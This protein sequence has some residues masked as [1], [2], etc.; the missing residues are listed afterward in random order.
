MKYN[1]EKCDN[2]TNLI[3]SAYIF[4]ALAIIFLTSSIAELKIKMY[5]KMKNH[6]YCIFYYRIKKNRK[7][8][9]IDKSMRKKISKLRLKLNLSVN[10]STNVYGID[11][12]KQ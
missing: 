8:I 10:I 2:L 12:I 9:G 3:S 1:I 11:A 6:I 5:L 4:S 7:T